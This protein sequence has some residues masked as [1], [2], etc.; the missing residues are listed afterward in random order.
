[1][2][3]A[4]NDLLDQLVLIVIHLSTWYTSEKNNEVHKNS[5]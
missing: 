5:L 1:M 3:Y 4:F 2:K